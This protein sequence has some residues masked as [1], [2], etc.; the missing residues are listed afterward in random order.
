[1]YRSESWPGSVF[2]HYYKAPFCD[3]AR[4]AG[5]FPK[6]TQNYQR[7]YRACGPHINNYVLL[8]R[9][10]AA[11]T[12][13]AGTPRWPAKINIQ[14]RPKANLARLHKT[15]DKQ[16]YILKP[17]TLARVPVRS[18]KATN[19]A[20][21]G[22]FTKRFFR[23]VARCARAASKPLRNEQRTRALAT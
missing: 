7:N 20:P 12:P 5:V 6:P 19:S 11:Q 10:P 15:S 13:P 17:R 14:Y 22:S 21:C 18:E 16:G 2:V 1:M 9:A 4:W 23:D 3:V 8:W